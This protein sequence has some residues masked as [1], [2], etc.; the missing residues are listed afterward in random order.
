MAGITDIEKS[1]ITTLADFISAQSIDKDC[2]SAFASVERPN[3][4]FDENSDEVIGGIFPIEKVSQRV[5][6]AF[7]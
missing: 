6:S 7:L 3:T 5:V 1:E 4:Q 2:R